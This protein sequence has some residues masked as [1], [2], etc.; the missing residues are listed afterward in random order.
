MAYIWTDTESIQNYLSAGSRIVIGTGK[1]QVPVSSAEI[2]ENEAVDEI[3]TIL[4]AAWSGV[5]DLD[6][7]TASRTLKW[8]AA[9]LA[10]SGIAV[11]NI[12]GS[13]AD[14]PKW[15]SQY[16][17]DVIGQASRMVVNFG[18]VQM[19]ESCSLH[20]NL[21]IGELLF[22]VKLRMGDAVPDV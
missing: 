11:V 17:S 1:D 3:T 19:P 21:D 6:T 20:E 5:Y 7:T 15:V 13:L 2:F 9:K 12:G 10:A 4:S 8:M 22:K 14:M 16:R 18:T